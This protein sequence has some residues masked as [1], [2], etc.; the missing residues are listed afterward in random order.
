MAAA[1]A[2]TGLDDTTRAAEA[3]GRWRRYSAE[4][5][6]IVLDMLLRNRPF[7][8]LL[9]GALPL[10]ADSSRA[11]GFA[12][13]QRIIREQ[14]PVRP[15][16]RLSSLGAAADAVA[17]NRMTDSSR[18]QR[19][20]RGDLD[21][22]VMKCLEKDRER[23]YATTAEL[24]EYNDIEDPEFVFSGQVITIPSPSGDFV[25]LPAPEPTHTPAPLKGV[26]DSEDGLNVRAEP[27]I[28]SERIDGLEAAEEVALTGATHDF[29]GE[30]WY[31]LE[32]GGWVL[33]EY[34]DI[35]SG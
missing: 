6:G 35:T 13:V 10:D 29:E 23:R 16:T 30:I 18:L 26:V 9:V 27:D 20:L 25:P 15:S 33:G 31:E 12:E 2:L 28:N 11:V 17:R 5:K 24:A 22:I 21:W 8:E 14:D 32:A 1:R 19:L 3:I 4:V 34:L 7:H